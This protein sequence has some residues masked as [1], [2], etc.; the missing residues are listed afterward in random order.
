[1]LLYHIRG[2]SKGNFDPDQS[3]QT[4]FLDAIENERRIFGLRTIFVPRCNF[5][6][7]VVKYGEEN[8]DWADGLARSRGLADG[9]IVEDPKVGIAIFNAD[10]PVVA[11]HDES[12]GK[13][14]VLHAGFRCLIRP[15]P[16]EKSIIQTLF[17]NRGFLPSAV[18]V[19]AGYGIGPCCYGAE[20]WP[21]INDCTRDLPLGRAT[22]GPRAGQRSVDL[23]YLIRQQLLEIGVSKSNMTFD[24]NCTSCD[25]GYYYSR[26]R[27]GPGSGNNMTMAWLK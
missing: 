9:G 26:C 18:K 16:R 21:E 14:A 23:Y 27:D 5:T 22:R 25:G 2:K 10:C 17:E 24:H 8:V 13:L 6:N 7:R 4:L 20:H 12:L 11:V 15:N 3:N 1:M 19:F